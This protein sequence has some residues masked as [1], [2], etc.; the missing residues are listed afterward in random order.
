[1]LKLIAGL[2]GFTALLGVFFY[3][4]FMPRIPELNSCHTS[5]KGYLVKV[6]RVLEYGVVWEV[7]L[8]KNNP[9]IDLMTY[10]TF[11]EFERDF[12]QSDCWTEIK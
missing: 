3:G 6:V 11:P 8:P 12:Q 1:M 7:Q 5:G 9:S 10:Q 2:I 4:A